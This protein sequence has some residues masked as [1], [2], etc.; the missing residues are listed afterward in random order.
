MSDD[1]NFFDRL[2]DDARPLRYEPNVT[3]ISA[4][5]RE[6]IAAQPT[7]AQ[8]LASWF[9]P[10]AATLTALALAAMIGVAWTSET[11]ELSLADESAIEIAGVSYGG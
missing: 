4:R 11:E 7:V 8:L 10:L 3:R 1:D 6:R 5:V 9:R 2:R